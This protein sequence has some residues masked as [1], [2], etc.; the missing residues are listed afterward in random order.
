L[1]FDPGT[2]H[3][4]SNAGFTILQLII[5]RV[6][7]EKYEPFIHQ[8]V[9]RPMRITRMHLERPGGYGPD[10]TRRYEP[11]G[12]RPA[13]RRA[14]NW[15]AP[16][17]AL[18][19]FAAAVAGSGGRPTFLNPRTMALMLEYPPSLRAAGREK[20]RPVHVGLGWDNVQT[21]PDGTYRFSKN[22]GKPGVQAWLEHLETGIDWALM[23]N[24]GEPKENPNPLGEARKMMYAAFA[25]I[26]GR[27]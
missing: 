5:E 2:E 1:L 24:T 26:L 21:F 3:K 12:R 20:E 27:G 9:L 7:G 23:F 19:R 25:Q 13:P 22:G 6:T 4:Y 17:G 16:S 10:E 8:H 15:L 18:A 11:G 14:A